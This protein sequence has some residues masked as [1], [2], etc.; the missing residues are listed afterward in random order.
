MRWRAL[1][2]NKLTTSEKP[3]KKHK[4]VSHQTLATS[5]AIYSSTRGTHHLQNPSKRPS[6]ATN[7]T[8]MIGLLETSQS[9][10]LAIAG[11]YAGACADGPDE[12]QGDQNSMPRQLSEECHFV[13]SKKQRAF[14]L[15]SNHVF[16]LIPVCSYLASELW[17]LVCFGCL[18]SK[19]SIL[20]SSLI[21]VLKQR[22]PRPWQI[23]PNA[24]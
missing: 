23:M 7:L 18:W 9:A 21:Q 19:V 4:N 11:H 16:F 14:A 22:A 5:L 3:N 20:A 8:P 12:S 6:E 15:H 13:A 10:V 1:S 17:V 2:F 24:S